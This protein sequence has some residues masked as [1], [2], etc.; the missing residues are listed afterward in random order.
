MAVYTHLSESDIR[1]LLEQYDLGEL[2][3]YEGIAEGVENT[4]FLLLTEKGKFILTLFERRTRA[5]D[6]PYFLALMEHLDARGIHCP[7]PVADRSGRTLLRVKERPAVIITFLEGK[8]VH[9]VA[10][11]HLPLLGETCA[12]MHLA[13]QGF[14]MH[15]ANALSF[16]GWRQLARSIGDRADEIAPHLT[17][18]IEEELEFLARHWPQGLP[19]GPVHADLF[20][21]NVFFIKEEKD[22][23]HTLR[24][25][26]I[27]DF[28][29]A[30]DEYWAYDLA[31]C[32]NAWCFNARDVFRPERAR[33]L[34]ES[35]DAVRPLLPA[36]RQHMSLLARAAALR[37]LLTRSHDWLFHP[38][39]AKVTPKDPLEYL[40]K[41]EFFRTHPKPEDIQCLPI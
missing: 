15:R 21:D 2:Q 8:N 39:G 29:F 14:G 6:L 20:P 10:Q 30:C 28:Y 13:A 38:D 23:A 37:F 22:A 25:T 1:A 3:S 35:Y 16:D 24:L 17:L 18:L 26:G 7:R 31:I 33:A 41:L 5:E 27:I 32:L 12:R 11:S 4:N 9:T 34:F 19:S 40:R 36:E